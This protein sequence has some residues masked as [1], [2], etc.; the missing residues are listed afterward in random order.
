MLGFKMKGLSKATPQGSTS[1]AP[2]GFSP[3]AHSKH[4][5]FHR[6]EGAGYIY[7]YPGIGITRGSREGAGQPKAAGAPAQAQ[8]AQKQ[9]PPPASSSKVPG[10]GAPAPGAPSGAKPAAGAA[11]APAAGAAPAGA[12]PAGKVITDPK[13]LPPGFNDM[14]KKTRAVMTADWENVQKE[15][16]DRFGPAKPY[17]GDLRKAI[18]DHLEELG[19]QG[20]I[21]PSNV[22]K[23]KVMMGQMVAHG[24]AA[25]LDEKQLAEVMEENVRKLAHQE[26]ESAGRTL[27]DHGV[28]HLSANARMSDAIFDQLQKGGQQLDPADRFMAYQAWI[29][30]DMGYTIPAIARGGFAVNDS[31]HPQAS[32]VLVMQQR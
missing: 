5:G 21:I 3:I 25:G 7:W 30:H 17:K 15:M 9:T 8:A 16:E 26:L 31:Y 12:A 14:D 23:A 2:A 24:T 22:E 11:P 29:D 4:G 19:R 20:Y 28:R 6:K 10:G 27:G 18:G 13:E 32:A 1:K